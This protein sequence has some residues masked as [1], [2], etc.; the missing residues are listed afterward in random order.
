MNIRK[1]QETAFFLHNSLAKENSDVKVIDF[2]KR[3]DKRG[4]V[5]NNQKYEGEWE[6]EGD[7]EKSKGRCYFVCI[8]VYR[9]GHRSSGL[10]VGDD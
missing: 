8:G 1:R 9:A 7:N 2:L 6:D 4:I 5:S 3:A 10:A